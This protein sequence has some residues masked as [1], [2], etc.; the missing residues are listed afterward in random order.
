MKTNR[1]A[2][3]QR[4]SEKRNERPNAVDTPAQPQPERDQTVARNGGRGERVLWTMQRTEAPVNKGFQ[5]SRAV[6]NAETLL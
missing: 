6:G 1:G 5:G 2:A 4:H 3:T